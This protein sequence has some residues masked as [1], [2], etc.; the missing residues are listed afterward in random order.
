MGGRGAHVSI[1]VLR[2]RGR[3]GEER[4]FDGTAVYHCVKWPPG[5]LSQDRHRGDDRDREK[6]RTREAK[7]VCRRSKSCQDGLSPAWALH[8]YSFETWTAVR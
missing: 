3:G 5:E 8:K 4:E 7:Q 1:G 6:A 2:E